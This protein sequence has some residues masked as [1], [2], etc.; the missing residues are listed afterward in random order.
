MTIA[1]LSDLRQAVAEECMR[2]NHR[3]FAE[4]FPRMVRFAEN[5][6]Y[7][8]GGLPFVT[9]AVRVAEMESTADPLSFT[10][11][12]ATKPTDFLQARLL[13]WDGDIKTAPDYEPPQSFRLN[14]GTATTG[15]PSRYTI[16]GTSVLLSPLITGDLVFTYYARPAALASDD[17]TH[18]MLTNYPDLYFTAV[19]IEAYGYTRD[20]G[21]RQGAMADYSTIVNGLQTTDIKRK[22]GGT[23]L[24]P[25]IRG[26]WIRTP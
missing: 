4:A 13:L 17:D 22:A 3:G 15:Y 8:G 1:T 26:S 5:R 7:N 19:L 16:E 18:D 25:R 24:Y 2:A 6:I 14:R 21:R 12:V 23:P 10:A 9:P 11:G 20:N